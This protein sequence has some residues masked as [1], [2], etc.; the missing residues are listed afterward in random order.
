MVD[1]SLFGLKRKQAIYA[2]SRIKI[3]LRVYGSRALPS[4]E[5]NHREYMSKTDFLIF[6]L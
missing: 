4:L 2:G 1:F 5:E 6:L 3:A